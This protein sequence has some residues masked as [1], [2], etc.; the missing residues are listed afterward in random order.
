[1]VVVVVGGGDTHELALCAP[2]EQRGLH[3]DIVVTS[4]LVSFRLS[5][6]AA[7]NCRLEYP[8]YVVDRA[9]GIW[10]IHCTP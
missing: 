7:I 2:R 6:S 10:R 4:K 8:A 1:M 3:L 5:I 9:R